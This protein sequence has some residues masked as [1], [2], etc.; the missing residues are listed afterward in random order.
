MSGLR[1]IAGAVRQ[2]GAWNRVQQK[3]DHVVAVRTEPSL[4]EV[5]ERLD[6]T[7][8]DLR[9]ELRG[10][11]D[12]LRR[13]ADERSDHLAGEIRRLDD[14]LRRLSDAVQGL[15]D[16]CGEVRFDLDRLGPH[17]AA[18]EVRIADGERSEGPVET[19]PVE[20]AEARRLLDEVSREHERIRVRFSGLAL[21][22]E[23]LRKLEEARWP[24]SPGHPAAP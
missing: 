9:A 21:Y 4:G 2:N 15:R 18:L 14:D 12:D 11:V 10:A 17:V 19:D 3:L 7:G 16:Q 8:D 23:R 1:R 6:R 24:G 20:T 5:R 22:E 13:H